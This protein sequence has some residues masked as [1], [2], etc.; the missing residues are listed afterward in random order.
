MV[1]TDNGIAAI[2]NYEPI[3]TDPQEILNFWT[4]KLGKSKGKVLRRIY[5]YSPISRDDLAAKTDYT[6]AGGAFGNILG[7]LR[8]LGLIE[9]L[10]DKQVRISPELFPTKL[11]V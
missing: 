2:P 5:E 3:P 6:A 4:D 7:N 10:P 11:I 9:Y 8:T 1:A